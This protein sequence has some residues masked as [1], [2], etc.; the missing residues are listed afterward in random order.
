MNGAK[1]IKSDIL[2][3]E[4]YEI[5]HKSGLKI[6]VL[7]NNDVH[8]SS[9]AFTGC[10]NLGLIDYDSVLPFDVSKFDAILNN[11]E[12]TSEDDSNEENE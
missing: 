5:N 9:D 12:T 10:D 6:L 2:K 3:E 8:Y 7:P 11:A 1:L 4:Y